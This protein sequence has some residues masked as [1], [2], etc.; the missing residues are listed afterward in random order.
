MQE[1][2]DTKVSFSERFSE[3]LEQSGLT[4]AEVAAKT[5]LSRTAFIHYKSG[6]S[7]PGG[8]ELYKLAK[9]FG[10]TM[11]W[12]ITGEDGDGTPNQALI[13]LRTRMEEAEKKIEA[14][15]TGVIAFVKKF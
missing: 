15:K 3:L 4:Q 6:R 13:V 8:M 12:L 5:G 1:K 14:M 10:C 11:E 9:F 2:K 7:L